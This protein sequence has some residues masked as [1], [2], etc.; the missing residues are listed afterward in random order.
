[1]DTLKEDIEIVANQSVFNE[2][3]LKENTFFENVESF[4]SNNLNGEMFFSEFGTMY[5]RSNLA[6]VKAI[7]GITKDV[8]QYEVQLK[9][10]GPMRIG[11]A[12]QNCV[13]TDRLVVGNVIVLV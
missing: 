10:N 9:S 2:L 1:V 11:W 4:N 8:Y 12:S 3:L 13:F 5:S 6:T 7:N